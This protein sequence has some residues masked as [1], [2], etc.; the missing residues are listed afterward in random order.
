MLAL[1][2]HPEIGDTPGSALAFVLILVGYVV[3]GAGVLYLMIRLIRSFF[4]GGK[5]R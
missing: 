1:L 3:V 2:F 4:R 5:S